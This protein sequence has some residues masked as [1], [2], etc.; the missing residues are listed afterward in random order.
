MDI[1][2]ARSGDYCS[3]VSHDQTIRIFSPWKSVNSLEGGCSWHEIARPQVHGHDINCVT[4][5]QGK[6]TIALSAEL[7]IKLLESLKPCCLF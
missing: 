4:I 2:W 1:S 5:I 7:K 6:G 3:L